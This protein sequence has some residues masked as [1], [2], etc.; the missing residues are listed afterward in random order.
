MVAE[1]EGERDIEMKR[2]ALREA[3]K[4]ALLVLTKGFPWH[5]VLLAQ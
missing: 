4:D 5:L 3:V 2:T 1:G